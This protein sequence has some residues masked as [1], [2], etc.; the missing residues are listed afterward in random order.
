MAVSNLSATQLGG[1]AYRLSWSGTVGATFVAYSGGVE[2]WRGKATSVDLALVSMSTVEVVEST[3]TASGTWPARL[4]LSWHRVADAEYYRIDEYVDAAWT[5]RAR[6][7]D[8]DAT[9]YTW[10]TRVLEDETDHNFRIVPVD[11]AGNDGTAEELT[12]YMV[13][14]PDVPSV[15][16]LFSAGTLTITAT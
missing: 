4:T 14:V 6:R 12:A 5:E 9:D 1:D 10:T 15:S 2:V 16:G 3:E 8:T 11:A 7:T 13:R